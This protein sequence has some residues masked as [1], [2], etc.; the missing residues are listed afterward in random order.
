MVL[1]ACVIGLGILGK[2]YVTRLDDH[3]QVEVVGVADIIEARAR[4]VGK[5]VRAKVYT[6]Y[7]P[8]LHELRP[9]IAEA[10]LWTALPTMSSSKA[11]WA[12]SS[13]A[14]LTLTITS[15]CRRGCGAIERGVGLRARRRPTSC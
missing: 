14:S 3:P 10:R 7:V 2:Q 1:K 13:M 5:L 12:R 11:C 6:D 4:D 15:R 9:D 8:M